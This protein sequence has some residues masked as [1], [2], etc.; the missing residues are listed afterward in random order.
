VTTPDEPTG[1]PSDTGW[2]SY[3]PEPAAD[4]VAAPVE[5]PAPY[6]PESF[7]PEPS[8][9]E[10]TAA[11]D[12][13]PAYDEG[14]AVDEPATSEAALDEPAVVDEPVTEEA[15]TF[16]EPAAYDEPVTYDEPVA[17]EEPAP[18]LPAVADEPAFVDE[19]VAEPAHADEPLADESAD[20]PVGE[21]DVEPAGPP[22]RRSWAVLALA[23]T[24][25]LM[26]VATGFVWYQVRQHNQTEDARRA[27]LE[28][29]RD[30]ARVL[31]SYDYRTL[32]KDFAAG[33]AITTGS[34]SKQYAETTSKVVTPVATEKKA[35]V[36]AEV[37]TAGVV[38]ATP[39]TVVT[40]VFVNQVTTSS[41]ATGPKVD[42]SRVRMT[43]HHVG[44]RWLVS[45]V[46]AL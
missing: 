16:D 11:Y 42:L 20:E 41:L 4:E 5:D 25:L 21:A 23:L 33:K 45:N 43:L 3:E 2:P 6:A 34:F 29:S 36:K 24:T 26:A 10:G 44:G 46:E 12:E 14:L 7:E 30:A 8:A 32:T 15:P 35:V 39:S 31:F 13:L 38:R 27:G 19:A 17:F 9:P 40:I 28:T 18:E 37:V 1:R 22:A